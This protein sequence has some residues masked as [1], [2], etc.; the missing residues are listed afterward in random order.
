MAQ[1]VAIDHV[2]R[3][4]TLP[5]SLPDD[6]LTGVTLGVE[7]AAKALEPATTKQRRACLVAMVAVYPPRDDD[8]AASKVRFDIYHEALRDIPADILWLACMECMKTIKFF[9]MPAEIRNA[10]EA[11]L[12]MRR[13]D[14]ARMKALRDYR[15]IREESVEALT[16]EE[17]A[18]RAAASDAL[19][20]T[21]DAV[22]PLAAV[23]ESRGVEA[24]TV[25]VEGEPEVSDLA[26]AIL[27]ARLAAC[28]GRIGSDV[29]FLKKAALAD[30]RLVWPWLQ[31]RGWRALEA[32]YREACG[33]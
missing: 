17:Q 33:G 3:T 16:E 23:E 9:P 8:E 30:A 10:A 19:R 24:T 31:R 20:R 5:A 14:L 26:T 2:A 27:R 22:S 12:R 28:G 29:A 18:R 32:E 15:R 11:L 7:A 21:L 4:V 13:I 6:A 1:T 25:V